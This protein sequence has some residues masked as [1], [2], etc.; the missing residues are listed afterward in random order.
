MKAM[1]AQSG[2]AQRKAGMRKDQQGSEHVEGNTQ[3]NKIITTSNAT[4]TSQGIDL[5]KKIF[6]CWY[7][8]YLNHNG[9]HCE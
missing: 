9:I 6:N 1:K 2:Q 5:A 7:S 4:A 8:P 3:N